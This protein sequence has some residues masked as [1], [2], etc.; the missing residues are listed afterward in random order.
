MERDDLNVL[1]AFLAVAEE[2]SFTK[3]PNGSAP[4]SALRVVDEEQ[5]HVRNSSLTRGLP[6]DVE[7]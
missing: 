1:A 5:R 3:R 7:W 6:S 4:R 2:R